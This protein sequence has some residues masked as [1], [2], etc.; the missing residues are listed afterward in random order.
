[1]FG[2]A[3]G[4]LMLT[5]GAGLGWVIA[6]AVTHGLS[7]GL[8]GP[9]MQSLRADYFGRTHFGQIMGL[10]SP[11]ITVGKVGGPVLA[12]IFADRFGSYQVGF[13]V[14]AALAALGS[15]LFYVGNAAGG[16]IRCRMRSVRTRVLLRTSLRQRHGLT[17]AT[18][19]E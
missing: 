14:L 9:I 6:F 18:R 13:T 15:D 10:S 5:Y 19:I 16:R 12:G 4:L 1:M 11:I 2:H 17:L 8:R 3:G 7:W